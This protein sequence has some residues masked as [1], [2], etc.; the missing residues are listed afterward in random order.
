[1]TDNQR[2]LSALELLER[3]S[4]IDGEHHKAWVIDQVARCLLQENYDE[5]IEEYE[6]DGEY[7]WDHGVA[8]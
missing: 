3:Y 5:W 1:M 8:P 4:Q 7:E 2:I 6:E